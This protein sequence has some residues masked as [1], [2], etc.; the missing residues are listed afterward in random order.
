MNLKESKIWI[1]TGPIQAG[2]THFCM[3]LIGQAQAKGL[4]LAGVICPPVFIGEKKTAISIE[5]VKSHTRKT[6]ATARTSKKEGIFTEAW[7]FDEEVLKWGNQIL[8]ETEGS[9][10]LIVDELGPLEFNR[11]QG[12]QNGLL[13]IDKGEFKTAVVVIRPSLVETA[14]N[15]WPF[16]KVIEI[17]AHLQD[18][19]MKSLVEKILP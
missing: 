7:D 11:G 8:A 3:C 2:K 17:P 6:L 4:N 10:L 13:A 5:D 18:E 9:D 15:R 19:L 12:W 16:A 1:V 14:S